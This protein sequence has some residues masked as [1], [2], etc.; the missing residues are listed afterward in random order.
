[1]DNQEV[2]PVVVGVSCERSGAVGTSG[3]RSGAVGVSCGRSVAAGVSGER[4]VA[5]GGDVAVGGGWT[6]GAHRHRYIYR[7]RGGPHLSACLVPRRAGGGAMGAV[8]V[9]GGGPTRHR[10]RA[11]AMWGRPLLGLGAPRPSFAGASCWAGS[12]GSSSVQAL[13]W[14]GCCCVWKA[15]CPFMDAH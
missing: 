6:E 10:A 5:D 15:L 12:V 3:E 14:L 4:S 2:Q 1:M 8:G 11:R 13:A 9:G 7:R